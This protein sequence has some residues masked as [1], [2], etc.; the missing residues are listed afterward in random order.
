MER[1]QDLRKTTRITAGPDLLGGATME[2]KISYEDR[3]PQKA[4]D[5][6]QAAVN[7]LVEIKDS[8]AEVLSPP[9]LASTGPDRVS[10]AAAGLLA[11]FLIGPFA[12]S[13]R[14]ALR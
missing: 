9:T 1:V 2:L 4:H 7:Q 12:L 10:I 6:V 5:E 14:R 8:A 3:D 11:G 13:R